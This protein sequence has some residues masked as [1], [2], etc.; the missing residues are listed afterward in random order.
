MKKHRKNSTR[1]EFTKWLEFEETMEQQKEMTEVTPKDAPAEET[2]ERSDEVVNT[3]NAGAEAQKQAGLKKVAA[4]IAIVGVT[5]ILIITG[6]VLVKV[7]KQ[8]KANELVYQQ[9]AEE[10]DTRFNKDEYICCYS[11]MEQ[12]GE[13]VLIAHLGSPNFVISKTPVPEEPEWYEDGLKQCLNGEKT[14]QA[15]FAA[16][17]YMVLKHDKDYRFKSDD[18]ALG[19]A[20]FEQ[21]ELSKEQYQM[22]LQAFTFDLVYS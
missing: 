9:M 14:D 2:A 4:I 1:D 20:M 8:N 3:A 6:I 16:K 17:L 15:L 21:N 5:F 11:I 10:W 13:L 22:A 18:M 19:I 12:D 7:Y